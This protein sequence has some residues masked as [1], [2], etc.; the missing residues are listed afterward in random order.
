MGA[1]HRALGGGVA[2]FSFS[3]IAHWPIQYAPA[4][5]PPKKPLGSW[6]FD[7]CQFRNAS[8][9]GYYDAVLVRG[10]SNPF[11]DRPPGPAWRDVAHARDFTLFARTGATWPAWDVP[12]QG[13]CR[14][15]E[16]APVRA[17]PVPASSTSIDPPRAG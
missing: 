6:E 5:A 10:Q 15:R 14:P 1:Y 11:R 3:E 2:S 13:P 16:P 8:D 9:G 7:P 17:S 4:A 12:D